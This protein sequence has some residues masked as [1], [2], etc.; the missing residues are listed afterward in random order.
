MYVFSSFLGTCNMLVACVV[1]ASRRLRRCCPSPVTKK[2]PSNPVRR[3]LSYSMSACAMF[4]VY[5]ASVIE[6]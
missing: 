4:P 3:I 6:K 1:C 2:S 5:S